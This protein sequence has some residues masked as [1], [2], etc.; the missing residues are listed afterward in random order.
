MVIFCIEQHFR[1]CIRPSFLLIERTPAIFVDLLLIPTGM[2]FEQTK[3]MDKGMRREN[4]IHEDS[5]TNECESTPTRH[6]ARE[7]K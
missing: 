6:N 1:A 3:L 5:F 4:T 2:D 7:Y